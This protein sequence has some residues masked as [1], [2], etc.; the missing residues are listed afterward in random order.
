M[1]SLRRKLRQVLPGVPYSLHVHCRLDGI[2]P[3]YRIDHLSRPGILGLTGWE[4][5]RVIVISEMGGVEA[6]HQLAMVVFKLV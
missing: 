5:A 6:V 4:N 2:R 1:H 3:A